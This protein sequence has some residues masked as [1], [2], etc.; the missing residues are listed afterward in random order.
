MTAAF[1]ASQIRIEKDTDATVV[2][3][4]PNVVPETTASLWADYTFQEGVLQNLGL[5]GGIRYIGSSYADN[6]NIYKVPAVTLVD[7]GMHY[8]YKEW[9]FALNVNNVFDKRYVAGCSGIYGCNYGA[10]R[11]ATLKASYTW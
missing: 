10:G 6:Q 2:G 5:Q 3:K 4:R 11:V 7:L 1:S 9:D 8:K